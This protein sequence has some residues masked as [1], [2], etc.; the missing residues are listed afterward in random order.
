MAL[1]NLKDVCLRFGGPLLLDEVELVIRPGERVCLLGRNGAGKSSLMKV[2]DGQVEPDSGAVARAR[3]LRT[4][5][6][7]QMV[8]TDLTG[9]VSRV[10]RSGMADS[11]A[12]QDDDWRAELM[13]DDAIARLG[14]DPEADFET[15][16]GG[17]KRRTLLAR[18]LAAQPDLLLL[19]E[20]TNHLDL[21]SITWLE[22][23]LLARKGTL[24]F[25]THDRSFL[26]RLATRIIE[27]DRG[28]LTSWPGD[29]KT[30]LQAKEDALSAEDGQRYRFDRKLASEE[31]WLRQ[32]LKARRTRNEGRLRRLLEMREERAARRERTGTVNMRAAAAGRTGKLVIKADN[33]S[34]GY[35]AESI[36][37]G[38]STTIMRGDKIGLIGPNGSGKTTLLNLLLDRLAPDSGKIRHGTNLQPIYFD[39]LRGQLDP[40]ASVAE[41]VSPGQDMLN[42]GGSPRHVIGYLKDFLFSPERAK[43]P[44]KSL[45]GGERNRLLLA[46]LFTKPSNLM[47]LDEPTNDLDVETLELLEALLVDY[48]GTLLVVSHD[49]A[50]LNNVVTSTL[51]LEGRGRVS[52]YV[53]GYDD[54]LSQRPQAADEKAK[55]GGNA[56]KAK[57]RPKPDKPRKL[58]FN[59]KR[60]LAGL[61][62]KIETLEAEQADL[63][64]R[65][66]D[67]E[68][69]KA[70][71][72]IGLARDRLAQL[73]TELETVYA[74]WQELEELEGG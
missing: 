30:Y 17:A 74:R 1:I 53:G 70:G 33:L 56:T 68:F 62:E 40:E 38:F 13:V 51:V 35:G 57:P 14:L 36:I 15:L 31:A 5:L 28:W 65:M 19:D 60:E 4:A 63:Q 50:F 45:S 18:C 26:Q 29:Y 47:I 7:P 34:F 44:V 27:L 71:K 43:S 42:I 11:P 59:E 16:S 52:E 25:V 37:T 3:G 10:V 12:G 67:P 20:P 8:P 6:L 48:P 49:R 55:N 2:I 32:G 73:E 54:W 39:Q 69:Y 64:N 9:P 24:V 61:P 21:K 23:F 66:A 41:N 72:Q 58:G 22:E 46:K